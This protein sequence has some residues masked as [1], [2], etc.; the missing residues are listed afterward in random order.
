MTWQKQRA[1]MS[2]KTFSGREKF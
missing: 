2:N 1:E